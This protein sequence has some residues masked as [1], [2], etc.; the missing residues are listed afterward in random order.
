MNNITYRPAEQDELEGVVSL[1]ETTFR[2]FV[3]PEYTEEGINTFLDY[4]NMD[5]FIERNRNN[6]F[7]LVAHDGK[8]IVGTIHIRDYEHISL[9][10]VDKEY[11]QKGIARRLLEMAIDRCAKNNPDTQAITVNSSPYAVNA[12]EKLGF[13]R[14]GEAEIKNGI[15][16][17]P[18]KKILQARPA[19]RA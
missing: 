1:I 18:L 17:V 15:R 11:H 8:K 6:H 19:A 4:L 3:A 10:F 9:L 16:F 5:Q 13:T 12:Y 2:E 14:T 7:T